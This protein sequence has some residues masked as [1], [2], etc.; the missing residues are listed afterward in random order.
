MKFNADIYDEVLLRFKRKIKM[1]LYK[2]G[3][4]IVI[5]GTYKTGSTFIEHVINKYLEVEAF[6]IARR[7]SPSSL[8]ENKL[9]LHYKNT[10]ARHIRLFASQ[11]QM[12]LMQKYNIQPIISVRNIY[13]SIVS[14]R[15]HIASGNWFAQTGMH[16]P[17]EFNTYSIDKQFD[18]LIATLLPSTVNILIPWLDSPKVN[19]K[20]LAY[21]DM[22][23][24]KISFFKGIFTFYGVHYDADK[25]KFII[26]LLENESRGANSDIR[27]N[28]GVS[29]RGKEQLTREH[30][31]KI[32]KYLDA[33]P[34]DFNF[35]R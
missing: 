13:D 5:A 3:Q 7:E 35:I 31:S 9:L 6:E 27:L 26:E 30:I 1:S 4:K 34:Y 16:I 10:G 32:D 17:R 25:L 19:H 29:G 28:K 21:E 24:N 22:V 12:D 23:E 33:L 11:A 20:I 15:D 2:S 14:S 8:D 18:I